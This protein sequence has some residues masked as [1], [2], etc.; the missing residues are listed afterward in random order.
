MGELLSMAA[1]L[2]LDVFGIRTQFC[3]IYGK[4]WSFF[5]GIDDDAVIPAAR[6]ELSPGW[7][8]IA[9]SVPAAEEGWRVLL[10]KLGGF[11][12]NRAEH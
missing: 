3:E 12:K 2:I 10:D 4:R 8:M 1:E 7:G 5:R 6:I 9:E 11:L